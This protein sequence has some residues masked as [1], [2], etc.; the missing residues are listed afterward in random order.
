M[1]IRALG[2]Q[3]RAH[4][5]AHVHKQKDRQTKSFQRYY[6][7]HSIENTFYRQ[8]DKERQRLAFSRVEQT[9]ALPF[10]HYQYSP[11]PLGLRNC[12]L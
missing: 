3:A 1:Y 6:R 2:A 9:N 5:R 7:T 10:G 8:A 4:A 12:C 11:L